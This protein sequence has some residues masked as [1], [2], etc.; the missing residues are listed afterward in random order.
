MRHRLSSNS[1]ADRSGKGSRGTFPNAGAA[2]GAT[3]DDARLA[4][5]PVDD[6]TARLFIGQHPWQRENADR[7]GAALSALAD[8]LLALGGRVVVVPP[9]NPELVEVEIALLLGEGRAYNRAD[10]V[11]EPGGPSE[12]HANTVALWR[13]GQGSICTGYAL[14]N[15]RWRSHSWV[16][17]LGGAIIE[18]TELRDAYY[19]FELGDDGAE[20]FADL[21]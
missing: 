12:C 13:A 20:I 15:D 11:L 18:T 17:R 19:G 4:S 16:L 6:S 9:D 5:P 14:S 10:A 7:N 21:V 3:P 2:K 8:R 1:S